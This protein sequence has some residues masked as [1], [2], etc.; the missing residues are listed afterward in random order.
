MGGHQQSLKSERH[1]VGVTLL[2]KCSPL[3]EK[4]VVHKHG[5]VCFN[6]KLVYFPPDLSENSH[7]LLACIILHSTVKM[8]SFHILILVTGRSQWPRG[9]RRRSSAARLL[10]LWVR[11]PPGAW[12]FFVSV[13]CCQVEMSVTD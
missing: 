6:M 7:S 13:V 11:I 1:R 5:H 2:V 8:S 9:L 10:R 4:H 12:L 3:K